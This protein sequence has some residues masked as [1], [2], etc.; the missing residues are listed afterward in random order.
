M[1]LWQKL[2]IDWPCSV[3]EWLWQN[4]ILAIKAFLD[5]LTFRRIIIFVGILIIAMAAAQLLTADVAFVFAGDAMF[6]FEIATAVYL[7]AARGH[8]RHAVRVLA[9][10]FRRAIQNLANITRRPGTRHCRNANSIKRNPGATSPKQSDD[11]PGVMG[12]YFAFAQV[13]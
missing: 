12:R 3:G 7:V 10:A 2:T 6:Y 1:N 5:K 9:R 4:V 11:E 13:F 8:A